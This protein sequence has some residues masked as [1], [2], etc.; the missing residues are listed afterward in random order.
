MMKVHELTKLYKNSDPS[1]IINLMKDDGAQIPKETVDLE[2]LPSSLRPYYQQVADEYDREFKVKW[3]KFVD[4]NL[5]F[6]SP[7]L[8]NFEYF[9]EEDGLAGVKHEG[10]D[11]TTT[12]DDIGL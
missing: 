2:T 12:L 8:V 3:R 9:R 6:K 4:Q 5:V 11:V 10:N 7:Q 1:F